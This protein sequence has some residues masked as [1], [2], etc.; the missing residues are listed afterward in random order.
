M[1]DK[2]NEYSTGS[3][4]SN[5]SPD[6]DKWSLN[7]LPP[8]GHRDVG[9]Y[10]FRL[11]RNAVRERD[12]LQMPARW[13]SGYQAFRGDL[14]G[15]LTGMT[16][17]YR[18]RHRAFINILAANIHRTVANITAQQP[19]AEV[20]DMD[21][22]EDGAD[23]LMTNVIK[24]WWNESEQQVN[25]MDSVY[26]MEIYG[27]TVEKGVFD[28]ERL[29]PDTVVL[30]PFS[31]FPAPGV[32]ETL[33]DAPYLCH[34][35]PLDVEQV[36]ALYDVEG[37][38]ASDSYSLLGKERE[39]M[40][41]VPSAAGIHGSNF[42]G[43]YASETRHTPD[44]V[45]DI[46]EGKALVI[47]IWVRDPA[48][49]EIE[50]MGPDGEPIVI[51][52]DKY[53]GKIRVVTITNNGDLVLDDKPNPNVNH[54][55]DRSLAE[56]T[57]LCNHYPFALATSYR[58]TTCTWGFSMYEQ[59]ADIL[60]VFNELLARLTAYANLSLLPPLILP[61]DC[62][63]TRAHVNN[64]PGLILFPSTTA[65][66]Q[67]IRYLQVPN[68]PGFLFNLIQAYK[69][70]FDLVSQI[71]DVDRGRPPSQVTAASA[72]LAL[73]ERSAV[74]MRQKIRSI[75]KLV[76]MRGRWAVSFYQN[77]GVDKQT[78]DVDGTPV[79]FMGISLIHRKF[80]FLVES[81]STVGKTTLQKQEQAVQLYKLGAIDREAL[82]ETLNFPGW[83][84]IVERLGEKGLEAALQ[85]LIQAGLPEE[86]AAQLYQ[87][88]SQP[89][90]GPGNKPQNKQG[91]EGEERLTAEP[92]VPPPKGYQGQV[93]PEV[94]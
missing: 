39:E 68:P 49:E 77:F 65:A 17:G 19:V 55:I 28:V 60:K 79:E 78:V 83:K 52:R 37:V 66:S 27:T 1:A 12:R 64:K 56:N 69:D 35:Y 5:V 6:W 29:E 2:I 50:V 82:L 31:F 13:R 74:M 90:G 36:E 22:F 15:Q 54:A 41:P 18:T 46:S 14:W 32:W 10:F 16:R 71:E 88:L 87:Y 23:I 33:E 34:A 92:K 73:Q 67:G 57:Y 48:K 45:T 44:D 70:F 84:Q 58:D 62:G 8:P 85:I 42:P 4:L 59:T 26:N 80:K 24:N 11:F 75:D 81:G 72:I 63:V 38:N 7:N 43:N 89:Q 53:P 91:A 21:G 47:E 86:A 30:D 76:R 51:E 9:P 40:R 61:K 93:P 3:T 94:M 20:I 25:L